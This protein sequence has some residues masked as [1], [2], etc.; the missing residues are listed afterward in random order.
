MYNLLYDCFGLQDD[1]LE[2]EHIFYAASATPIKDKSVL[3][4][5]GQTL[6]A[7]LDVHWMTQTCDADTDYKERKCC[8]PSRNQ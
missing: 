4:T 3:G 5:P 7:N 1:A 8:R 2:T 6:C